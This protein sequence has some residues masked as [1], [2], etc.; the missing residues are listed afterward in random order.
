[1][2]GLGRSRR[3]FVLSSH[4]RDI[5]MAERMSYG[6]V[7]KSKEIEVQILLIWSAITFHPS[8]EIVL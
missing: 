5:D 1:M 2:I 7:V 3:R 8:A 6:D 4:M